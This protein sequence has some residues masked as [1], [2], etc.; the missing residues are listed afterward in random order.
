MQTES[1]N[2]DHRFVGYYETQSTSEQTR[3]R[4][5]GKRQAIL[6][7][8]AQFGL[9]NERLDV[10][11]IGCGPGTETLLWAADGHCARGI[12]ISAPL[13]E[14][15]RKRADE[16]GLSADFE[17]SSAVKL[18]FANCSF[19]IVLVTELLEHLP[20]WQPCVNEAVRIL[21]PGGVVF[22]S[23]TNRLCPIQQ[24]FALPGYSWY[25]T[26]FKRRCERL[27]VT[28]H[29]HWVQYADFPAVH[30]F[31]FYQLRDYLANFGIRTYDR[32]DIMSADDSRLRGSA[33]AIIRAARLVRFAAHT[34]TPY[35]VILGYRSV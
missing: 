12:D 6:R 32:F 1:A 17:V 9:P 26:V 3:R 29:R 21:R 14:I 20:Q 34:L 15:A 24:E 25:P 8:R 33:L 35:T 5:D 16:L 13:I 7:L 30:W 2:A 28:T 4:F 10:A 18:P 11:D 23:T 22:L 19:D 31:S 27:A